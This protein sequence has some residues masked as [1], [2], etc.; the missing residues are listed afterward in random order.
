[1]L[2]AWITLTQES[3]Y[4]KATAV[5]GY[6]VQI[7]VDKGNGLQSSTWNMFIRGHNC[8]HI[9]ITRPDNLGY[10][11]ICSSSGALEHPDP[12]IRPNYNCINPTP[13]V[14]YFCQET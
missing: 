9:A 10:R 3:E 13:R 7:D 2:P 8:N 11:Q 12:V 14:P 1:M 4:H 6:V 5:V